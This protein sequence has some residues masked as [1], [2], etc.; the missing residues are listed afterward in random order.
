MKST[1]ENPVF[2]DNFYGC[3]LGNFGYK[4]YF[5]R[6]FSLFGELDMVYI[7]RKTSKEGAGMVL[8]QCGFTY[9]F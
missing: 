3:L 9:I 1:K 6:Y 8:L 7:F 5:T 4:H 2:S